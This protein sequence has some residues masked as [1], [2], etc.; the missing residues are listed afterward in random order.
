MNC[1][2]RLRAAFFAYADL[3]SELANLRQVEGAMP[4]A[5]LG[6]NVK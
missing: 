6:K 1:T 2:R 5:A 4:V 3:L